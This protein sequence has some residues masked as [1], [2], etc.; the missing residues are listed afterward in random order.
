MLGRPGEIRG[1]RL[2]ER[3][4]R[5]WTIIVDAVGDDPVTDSRGVYQQTWVDLCERFSAE[6]DLV[7]EGESLTA[8][9]VGDLA[10]TA[11]VIESCIP[12]SEL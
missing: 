4:R 7:I 12:A 10:R 9:Y 3:L 1:G 8:I 5:L 2:A 11:E 6:G